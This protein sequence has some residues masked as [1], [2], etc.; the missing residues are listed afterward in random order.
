MWGWIHRN[1]AGIALGL[2]F[3][4]MAAS[5][6]AFMVFRSIAT[7]FGLPLRHAAEGLVLVQGFLASFAIGLAYFAINYRPTGYSQSRPSMFARS[8]FVSVALAVSFFTLASIVFA[9]GPS[10]GPKN[11]PLAVSAKEM[12]EPVAWTQFGLGDDP[13]LIARVLL[14]PSSQCPFIKFDGT[15][16]QMRERVHPATRV[17]GRLCEKRLPWANRDIKITIWYPEK[18]RRLLDYTVRHDPKSIVVLGDTGCRLAYH[19]DQ[20]CHSDA[21][22][23]FGMIADSAANKAPDLILHLGDYY[24]R[25]TP[26]KATSVDCQLSPFGDREESWRIDFFTPVGRLLNKA[27]WVFVRGNHEDCNRGGYGWFY[28]LGDGDASACKQAHKTAYVKMDGLTFLNIDT[29]HAGDEHAPTDPPNEWAQVTAKKL[30]DKL[31]ADGPVFLLTHKPLYAVCD[32]FKNAGKPT[33]FACGRPTDGLD[34]VRGIY[35]TLQGIAAGRP[36][37]VLGGDIHAFQLFDFAS[38]GDPSR[39]K[40][41]ATQVILGNGGAK[42]DNYSTMGGFGPFDYQEFRLQPDDPAKN[43]LAFVGTARVS[44]EFGFGVVEVSRG[45][46]PSIKLIVHDVNGAAQFTCSLSAGP[47]GC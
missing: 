4:V 24:Y 43:T 32:K 25:E 28:Y 26:C 22:W 34:H 20:G 30:T 8:L 3:A 21:T 31:A 36:T 45:S 13:Q 5:V 41:A 23:P 18:D 2:S 19:V 7:D 10:S 42:L 9:V 38:G 27:P 44:S 11:E 33:S 40:L 35:E 15:V 17:F 16:E 12:T 6:A 47:K 46:T 14:D 29:A 39:P 37:V 1:V